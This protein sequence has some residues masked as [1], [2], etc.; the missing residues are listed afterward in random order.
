ME[1]I[2]KNNEIEDYVKE[3]R[4]KHF[5]NS[6]SLVTTK[7]ED[8]ISLKDFE[9]AYEEGYSVII[10]F[11]AIHENQLTTTLDGFKVVC[12]LSEYKG[13]TRWALE[14]SNEAIITNIDM[15]KNV[16]TVSCIAATQKIKE[17]RKTITEK[18]DEKI[19]SQINK[20][21]KAIYPVKIFKIVDNDKSKLC[22]G[23]VAGTG[24][25]CLI[26]ARDFA[27][28]YVESLLDFVKV[29]DWFDVEMIS[30]RERKDQKHYWNGSRI[31]IA[32]NPWTQ[33]NIDNK[34][35]KGDLLIVKCISHGKGGTWWWGT[36]V[37]VPGIQLFCDYSKKFSI[38]I[39]MFYKCY[40]KEA[41]ATEKR[42]KVAPISKI[43]M[44][45]V[46]IKN[47]TIAFTKD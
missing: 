28:N 47:A 26:Y 23:S 38:E 12:P 25:T 19:E 20:G 30:R 17:R 13:N 24:V 43:E 16:V 6:G 1:I 32:E 31:S 42:F 10:R 34:F 21:E 18:L 27:P 2:S 14:K 29:G 8:A 9:K 15:E 7:L 44:K 22:I 3:I 46:G 41:N 37:D 11:H 36:C 40:V 33:E 45:S 39:G 5:V 35:K 4:E